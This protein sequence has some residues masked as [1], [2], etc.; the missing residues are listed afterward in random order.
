MAA[1]PGATD[2]RSFTERSR[3]GWEDAAAGKGCA[4]RVLVTTASD[5]ETGAIGARIGSVLRGRGHVVDVRAPD[6]VIDV[7]KY[8]IV[9]LGSVPDHGHWAEDARLLVLRAE[10]E[11]AS[12]PVWL[13]TSGC[14]P[15]NGSVID[16]SDVMT[17][18]H[19]Y[20]H[21]AFPASRGHR[22]S[23]GGTT[24]VVL[25]PEDD[26]W[27]DVDRWASSIADSISSG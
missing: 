13:F 16:V 12:R 7:D 8:D 23:D 18:T 4:M 26:G 10:G 11:L 9:V 21:R 25:E 22:A 5:E 20:E 27:D 14:A 3:G 15:S 17:A 2:D 6:A 1:T 24:T 19:A